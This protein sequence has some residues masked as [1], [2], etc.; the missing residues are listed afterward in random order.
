[1]FVA[2]GA[3][4]QAPAPLRLPLDVSAAQAAA[5]LEAAG[6]RRRAADP[7]YNERLPSGGTRRVAADPAVSTHTRVA[8]DV[9]ES[10]FMRAGETGP[11]QLFYSA[12]GD[13]AGV[14]AR[15]AGVAGGVAGRSGDGRL[16]VPARPSRLTDG[17]YQFTIVFHRPRATPP[18]R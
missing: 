10:V 5:Q 7:P 3:A 6:F 16:V 8:G 14:H 2:T 11:A 12:Y 9:T 1:M 13:S 15:F 18:V 17:S 4:A